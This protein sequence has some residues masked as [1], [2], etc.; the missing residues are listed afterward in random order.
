MATILKDFFKTGLADNEYRAGKNGFHKAENVDIHSTPSLIKCQQDTVQD[1]DITI[2]KPVAIVKSTN[3]KTYFFGENGAIYSRTSAGVWS[4]E[5]TDVAPASGDSTILDALEYNGYIY[6]TMPERLGRWAVGGTNWTSRDDDYQ[7]LN[8]EDKY[9]PLYELESKLYV[10]DVTRLSKL[11]IN[12]TYLVDA[13]GV[14]LPTGQ[15]IQ[16]LSSY[17]T[18]VMIGTFSEGSTTNVLNAN[19]KVFLWDGILEGVNTE[20][21]LDEFGVN[22]MIPYSN[23]IL[24]SVGK[25]GNLYTFTGT[26]FVPYKKIPADYSGNNTITIEKNA[27][28]NYKGITHLGVSKLD[29]DINPIS[30][31]VYTLGGYSGGYEDVLNLDY[32]LSGG[33]TNIEI[34]AIT[35]IDENTILIGYKTGTTGRVDKIDL[36]N[37]AD[38]FLDTGLL[39][40]DGKLERSRVEIHYKD[41]PDD[42][43]ITLQQKLNGSTSWNNVTLVQDDK[44]KYM[45]TKVR[46]DQST[47]SQFKISM[48]ANNNDTPS[49]EKI[50]IK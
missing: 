37:K 14:A 12:S 22:T 1:N 17:G 27:W 34:G 40:F 42:T 33:S 30:E 47:S 23:T 13:I 26:R 29:D 36:S 28:M 4:T 9:H 10:G 15:K 20:I 49:I 18:K 24:I 2:Q 46:I 7:T 50:I 41:I 25:K 8:F 16:T 19:S 6:Y 3:G 35:A 48:F 5:V 43:S 38:A 11:D 45:Y 21:P 44:R 32:I 39:D 31:G